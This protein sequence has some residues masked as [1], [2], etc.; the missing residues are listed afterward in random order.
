MRI[1]ELEIT[2]VIDGEIAIPT[3]Q[4]WAGKTNDDWGDFSFTGCHLTQDPVETV[5]SFLIRGLGNRLALVDAG[6]G[7]NPTFPFSGGAL[8]SA[9]LGMDVHPNDI[10]DVLFTHL[11]VD[12]IGWAT[13]NGKPFF[14]NAT[15]RCDS[16]D[17]DYFMAPEYQDP[18]WMN[19]LA[20]P[21][22]DSPKARL[23]PVTDRMEFWTG[24]EEIFPGLEAL[25]APGHTPGSSI[26]RLRSDDEEGYILGDLVHG[27]AELTDDS[28]QLP[29]HFDGERASES[30]QQWRRVLYDTRAPFVASHFPGM[31]WG[32]FSQPGEF[33]NLPV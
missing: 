29:A 8:R 25:D 11:H 4:V 17:W 15:Y 14:E 13:L 12:H 32:R 18:E 9:L 16:R 2:S 23:G 26:L 10:T 33:E 3:D 30:I 19:W 6:M 27:Y 20:K 22:F 5:G 1:G 21:E 31:R 24:D 7:N 28:W